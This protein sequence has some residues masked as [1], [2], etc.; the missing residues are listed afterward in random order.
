MTLSEAIKTRH[1]V[2][3][4]TNKK[5]EG[6]TLARLQEVI[7]ECNDKSGMHIQLCLNEPKAF[8][9]MMARYGKFNNVNN[10]IALVGKKK[11][12]IE[13]TYG[14]Y[15]EKIVL[16]AQIL[17]L[18]TCWVAMSYS[19]GKS[20]AVI[21]PEEKLFMVISVGYGQTQ[22][23]PHKVKTIEELCGDSAADAPEWFLS[24]MKA[25]QLAPTAMNQ[26]KF[27]IRRNGNAVTATA[28][29]GFYS[30]VDLGIVKYHFE[31]GAGAADWHW[32]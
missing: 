23:V 28:G 3:S 22:G 19:K 24:G 17:G 13:E 2:R 31:V 9:G 16:E 11:G 5:I 15:G 10:Y 12:N 6:D 25:A 18:N 4:Y 1:S 14:Y 20:Q 7:K 32:E 27:R 21:G 26:Q 29:S 8:S 30:K